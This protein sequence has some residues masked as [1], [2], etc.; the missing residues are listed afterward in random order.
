[1]ARKCMGSDQVQIKAKG[2]DNLFT[3][4]QQWSNSWA[5]QKHYYA[6]FGREASTSS[7]SLKKFQL[8]LLS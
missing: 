5:L 1:M 4:S 7:T 2:H 8:L 3:K 6:L